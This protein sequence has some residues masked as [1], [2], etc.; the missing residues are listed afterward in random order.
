MASKKASQANGS[1]LQFLLLNQ[2]YTPDPA[3]T[4]RYLHD[5]AR[6]LVGRG[7]L[8]RVVCS[9]HAYA[10]GEDLGGGARLDRVDVCRVRG[11]PIGP[12]SLA[13]RAAGHVVYFAQAA[14]EAL[15]RE[16]RPDLV[17]AAT[18]PPFLGL[19][20][21]VASRWRGIPHAEWTMDVYP[22]VLQAHWRAEGRSG[23][24]RLLD[25][26]AR[27]QL[28]RASLVLT[29]GTYMADRV[30]RYVARGTHVETVPLWSDAAADEAATGNG[31][32]AR[33]G[34]RDEDLV[35]LYSGNMGRGH[36]FAEFLEA[37]GRLGA[38]GPVWAF[39]GGGPR[40]VEVE[41]F[42]QDHPAA[43][44]ELLPAVAPEDVAGSLRSGDVHLVS[45]AAPWQGVIVPSKLPA[46]F[47]I[48]RPV[49]FVGAPQNEIASC[50]TESGG[51][52]VVGEGDVDG[53]TR[54]VDEARDPAV[55]A[56]R[57]EAGRQYARAH[58][59][60]KRNAGRVADLLEQAASGRQG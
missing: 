12:E 35:L 4:G 21:A 10:T 3:P 25:G 41:R 26:L 34:W 46:A 37:A 6:E 13:G 9:R 22:D 1:K 24:R 36:R 32:R 51:G 47:A 48:G 2:F 57:G 7:H 55:R 43:R 15:F 29:L 16:P 28:R 60:R 59:D 20:G 54:A 56:R 11:L 39:V 53:L 45:L 49:I 17:L 8:V 27:F 18:S 30:A 42:R 38:E 19:A 31:W 14:A 50:I 40:R 33:R 44:V 58:F 52:W 5:V 23:S